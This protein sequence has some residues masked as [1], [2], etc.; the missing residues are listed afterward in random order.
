MLVLSRR[1][2]EKILVGNNI[3]VTVVEVRGDRV[4]I[5]IEAPKDVPIAR[6]DCRKNPIPTAWGKV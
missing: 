3:I 6:D 4:K 2:G 1:V 5:G